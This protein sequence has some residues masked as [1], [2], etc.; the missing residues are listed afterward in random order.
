MISAVVLAAGEGR[1]TW[2]FSGIRQK[3]TV[4]VLHVPMVRRMVLQL[5]DLG[6]SE[7]VV[8][9][10]H[11]AE[12]VQ[13]CVLDIPAVRCVRQAVCRGPVDAAL[14]GLAAVS[15]DAVLLC[16]A[17][18]VTTR[19]TLRQTLDAYTHSGGA[20][21]LLGA[22]CPGG[23]HH[24]VTLEC[25]DSGALTGVWARGE[26][27]R[28]RFVGVAVAP[29]AR[30]RQYFDRNPGIMEN[31]GV[32]SMPPVEGDLAFSF[33]LMRRDGIETRCVIARDFVVDVDR[34]WDI[35][36]ANKQAL[37]YAIASVPENRIDPDARIHD[38]AEIA[39]DAR[40][41]A[42]AGAQV[43]KGCIIQGSAILMSGAQVRHGAIL[44]SG[45]SIGHRARVEEYAKI[46][47]ESV[48]GDDSVLAHCAEFSG[49]TFDTVLMY[50]YCCISALIGTHVDIGAATVC[51]TWRFDDGVRRQYVAG[52]WETPAWHGNLSY[53]G[54]YARTG[55]NA[56]FMPGV[57]VGCYCCVGPGVIVSEDIPER[58]MLLAAQRQIQKEWGPEHYGW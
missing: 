39:A 34:P 3:T 43:G 50:H 46:H 13:A 4:P 37:G 40:L 32:G 41:I 18:I 38:G 47:A 53:I 36:E 55:V 31:T 12:A 17:D 26:C 20:G 42:Q 58:K 44:G 51:G 35:V 29:T 52:H 5:A 14:M 57:K 56:T 7:I 28:P 6:I 22:P 25:D 24:W 21:V 16:C 33:E 9:T 30:L 45:V 49:I 54:D 10:G 48:L 11:R 27:A 19:D 15:G 8:V 23:L 1:G 2:P